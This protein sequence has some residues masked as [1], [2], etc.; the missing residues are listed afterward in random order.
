MFEICSKIDCTGCTACFNV[1]PKNAI[2]MQPDQMGFLYPVVD[3][4]LCIDCK[5]CERICPVHHPLGSLRPQEVYAAFSK[6]EETRKSSASGGLA[7][8]FSKNILMQ[9]GVVYGCAQYN[10]RDIKHVRVDRIEDLCLLQGSKYVQSSIGTVFQQV[11][12]DLCIGKKVLFIGTSCQVAG[13]LNYLRKPYDNLF[14]IDLLCHGVASQKMLEDNVLFYYPKADECVYV[15]FR[16][17][18][19]NRIRYGFYLKNKRD[20]CTI[21]SKDYPKDA[22]ITSFIN[23]LSLR[24]NCHNCVY[25]GIQRISDITI[26]DFWG[27]KSQK[28]EDKGRGVSLVLINSSRGLDLFQ[29][30]QSNLIYEKRSIE[31]AIRGNG[32]LQCARKRPQNKELFQRIYQKKGLQRASDICNAQIR[33]Q[34]RMVLFKMKI[35]RFFSVL[36]SSIRQ[37]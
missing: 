29:L 1:C 35:K 24:E 18:C 4:S 34:Y 25:S 9:G 30:I 10:F 19:S 33:Q 28:I 31:E 13:L 11:K 7:S 23:H 3:Q 15:D 8:E 32:Q 6:N 26:A 17:K 16:K 37:R 2:T 12:S 36:L 5:L 21:I 14:T 22:Y 27:L 20:G